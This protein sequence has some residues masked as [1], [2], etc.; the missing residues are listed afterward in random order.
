MST[1]QFGLTGIWKFETFGLRVERWDVYSAL[2]SWKKELFDAGLS[3]CMRSEFRD[4]TDLGL[5][6]IS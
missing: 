6:R 2:R 3:T 5:G 4:A 1:I